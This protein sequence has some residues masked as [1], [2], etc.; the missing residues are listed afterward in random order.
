MNR[1]TKMMTQKMIQ[2]QHEIRKLQYEKENPKKRSRKDIIAITIS[3]PLIL[4]IMYLSL[5]I[6]F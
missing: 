3:I 6:W 1:N 2:R 4:I 5:K